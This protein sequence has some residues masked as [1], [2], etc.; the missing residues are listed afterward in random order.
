MEMKTRIIVAAVAIPVLFIILFFLQ[1]IFLAVLTAIICAVAA[2]EF[3]KAVCP[4]SNL[5]MKVYT[6]ACAAAIP[7]VMLTEMSFAL[8]RGLLVLLLLCL[9][10]EGISS[11]GKEN[12]I[13]FES[14]AACVFA[15]FVYPLMMSS[16]VTLKAMENG[17]LFVLLP[18]VVTFCCD[19]GAYF[20][21]MFMGKN[22][23]TAVSPKKSVEGYIGGI[24]S[25]VVCMFIYGG[26]VAL[27]TELTVNFLALAVYGA[28][29]SVAVEIGDLA[30]SLI[31][32]QKG[33]KDYG[34]L[35]PGHGGMLDR[36]DSMSFA[37][38]LV[39]ALVSVW[40]VFM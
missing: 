5:F 16:L 25:G 3:M 11:Y 40:P 1:P 30:F 4:D 6:M 34:N 27:S 17:K 26:I 35:I 10:W 13:S 28:A 15:G 36:F 39:C 29:G 24:V 21:G 14:I 37:A 7:I 12:A 2:Y 31:K 8:S 23:K 33:I 18:V 20:V 19:S 9:F 38:P 22:R 32:R